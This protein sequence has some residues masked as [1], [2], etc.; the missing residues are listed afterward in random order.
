MG[1]LHCITLDIVQAL[2]RRVALN[3]RGVSIGPWRGVP[4]GI[5][6]IVLRYKDFIHP[7]DCGY[8]YECVFLALCMQRHVLGHIKLGQ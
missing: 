8:E 5:D 2:G 3:G 6:K 7:E 1:G 4:V